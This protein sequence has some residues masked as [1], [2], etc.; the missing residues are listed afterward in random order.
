M[1]FDPKKHHRRSIR[2]PGYDYSAPGA[3][4]ITLC[5]HRR[6][7]L[8]GEIVNGEMR[9]N[10]AGN[11]IDSFISKIP[12]RYPEIS[13]DIHVV[14][15][16]HVHMIWTIKNRM[17][18]GVGPI[19]ELALPEQSGR[20]KRRLARRGML[21][22]KSIGYYRMNTAKQI[23]AIRHMPGVP[24][25]QQDYFERCIRDENELCRTRRYIL[26]NPARWTAQKSL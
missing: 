6:E 13:S 21:I 24:V 19:H 16:D 2:L 1:A 17:D 23:N 25:W 20:E 14:M 18:P 12:V 22:P 8:F 11:I 3:Y 4:F 5:T 15:P 7:H 26:E 10:A 9:L